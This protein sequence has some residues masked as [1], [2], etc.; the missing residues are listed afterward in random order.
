MKNFTSREMKNL[1]ESDT[2][3]CQMK[4]EE[5]KEQIFGLIGDGEYM[6]EKVN[7]KVKSFDDYEKACKFRD[8]VNRQTQ[9]SSYKG[10]LIWYVWY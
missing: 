4:T 5:L 10:K 3:I 1:R 6:Q 7:M 2:E 9:W 8:K